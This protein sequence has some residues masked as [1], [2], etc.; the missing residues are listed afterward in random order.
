[1]TVSAAGAVIGLVIAIIMIFIK[2]PPV[3]SLLT[4]A[5]AG[6]LIGGADLSS[7]IDFM[8][9][10]A[11]GMVPAALRVLAAGVLAGVMIETGAATSIAT[12][13]VRA[14]GEKKALFALVLA[15]WLLTAVG[16]FI[17]V[18]IMT[19]ATIAMAIAYQANLS[20]PAILLAMVGGGK[21]GNIMSP[22]PN[23]IALADAFDLPLTT[24]M[25]AGIPAGIFGIFAAYFLSQRLKKKG[26]FVEEDETP[27]TAEHLPAVWTSAAAPAAAI[28]LLLLNPAA[29]IEIDPLVALPAGALFGALVMK[30]TDM[31]SYCALSGLG[32][33]SPVAVLLICTGTIAGII[34]NS[35]VAVIVTG[36]TEAAGMPAFVIAPLSGIVM[37]AATG[38]TT[39]AAVVS[40]E[41]FGERLIE[42][43]VDPLSAAVMIHGGANMLD[44]A[45]V[46][47]FFH[48][49]A[50][51]V[52]MGM[53]ERLKLFPY[54][55]A[56]GSV[57]MIVPVILFGWI[58]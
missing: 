41:V 12:A 55:A 13:I 42:S 9:E 10:G 14:I 27:E 15:A 22:N 24:L 25:A 8:M 2:F 50:A 44:H 33:V 11:E 6:G 21:A 30:K 3:Y 5:V 17:V 43:G 7:T 1:M 47:S 54:E 46:G 23:T 52:G 28:G 45:P 58:W 19:V 31:F 16:V 51:A 56:V 57:V 18:A 36:M 34:S 35:N 37:G 29:G 48:A 26:S 32:K 49:T 39:A 4:G 20:K 38:S 40:A 53:K